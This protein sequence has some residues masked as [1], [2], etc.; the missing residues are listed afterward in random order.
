MLVYITLHTYHLYCTSAGVGRTGTFIATDVQLQRLSA[1]RP[2]NV[3]E[4]VCQMRAERSSCVQTKVLYHLSLPSPS[5]SPPPSHH[6]LFPPITFPQ[7]QYRFIYEVLLHAMLYGNTQLS[8]QQLKDGIPNLSDR[9]DREFQVRICACME[10]VV[11]LAVRV[12]MILK[13][14]AIQI[15]IQNKTYLQ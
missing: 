9:V 7:E 4:Y 14:K 2:L 12:V 3:Q 5:P 6:L 1:K 8:A 15:Q 13:L 11:Q 10:V